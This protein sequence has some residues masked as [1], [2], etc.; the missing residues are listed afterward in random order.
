MDASLIRIAIVVCVCLVGLAGENNLALAQGAPLARPVQ[1][2]LMGPLDVTRVKEGTHVLARVVED[3][4]DEGCSL[5][6][7]AIVEGHIVQVMRRS[8]AEKT[9]A[10]Q[11][12]FDRADC[13]NHPSTE[14]KF[15]LI[16]LIGPFGDAPP[17]GQPGLIVGPPLADAPG[18]MI[19]GSGGGGGMM[20]SASTASAINDYS[21]MA[22]PT[23]KRPAQILSGQVID[24]PRTDLVVGAGTDGATVVSASKR[25]V[26]LEA[27]TTLILLPAMLARKPPATSGHSG[28]LAASERPG[29][30]N[31][32]GG[33]ASNAT[34]STS[35]AVTPTVLPEP[36]D[37]T[38]ICSGAC[39]E[40][41]A[42]ASRAAGTSVISAALPISQLGFAPHDNQRA[43]SFDHETTLTYLDPTHLLCTFDPHRLRSRS[44]D[45]SDAIRSIRAVLIDTSTHTIDRVMEWRVR[46]N[47]SYLWRFGRG[48]VLVHM[49]HELRMFDAELRSLKSIPVDGPVA[50]VVSSPSSD[51]IAVGVIKERYSEAVHSQLQDMYQ[52]ADEDIEVRV[53][54]QN[55]D[56]LTAVIRSTRTVPPVLSDGGELRATRVSRG[57]W[58]INEYRWDRTEHDVATVKTICRPLLS[59]PEHGLIF[60]TGCMSTTGGTWYRMLRADGHPLLKGESPAD[61]IAQSA[62][63]VSGGSFAVRVVKAA[64]PMNVDQ[65]FNRMDLTR[66][67]IGIY[68]SSDG[69]NLS[70]V[71]T[72]DFILAQNSYALS[73]GGDQMAIVGKSS[74]LFYPLKMRQ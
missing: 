40:V 53:Y 17:T 73:P 56:L 44:K 24:V 48:Q 6:S 49:G 55:L 32:G 65:A 19:G 69:A 25:D 20:R 42:M 37:E 57:R 64:K 61:E 28:L 15:T 38:E 14:Y 60:V 70:S 54:D 50:W 62:E 45:D 34:A 27:R 4:K 47:D 8:K 72:D 12:V 31:T 71:M 41:G 23:R 33:A 51:H 39:N 43:V 26:R 1:A 74:I 59:A 9:S 13:N 63:G 3:W 35:A 30:Q 22:G 66:E 16:A 2:E 10:M 36:A 18:L 5:R 67:E 46:G 29:S 21:P 58:K 11:I 7:G 68:G 52:E